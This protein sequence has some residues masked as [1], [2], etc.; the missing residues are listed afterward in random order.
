L[1]PYFEPH[2]RET[3]VQRGMHELDSI[4]YPNN[5]PLTVRAD[6]RPETGKPASTVELLQTQLLE[7]FGLQTAILN[8]LYGVQ[9]PFS[10]DMGAAYARALNDW[11]RA[12]WLDKDDRFRASI[13]IPTQSPELAV[14]EIERCAPDKRFVQVL[15]LVMG[16]TTLGRRHHWPIYKAAERHGLPIGIHAGSNYRHPVTPIGWP[17]TSAEDY[18]NQSIAFQSQLASLIAE[19]VFKAHPGLKFVF[20]ESGISWLPSF[21]WRFKK[22]WRGLTMEIPWVDRPP[23]EIVRDQV[24]FS[25]QPFDGATGH[26]DTEKLFEHLGSDD[27]ILFSTDYPHWQFDGLNA[28][29]DGVPQS[30]LQKIL[31][32]NPRQTY[33]RL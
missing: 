5:S 26:A 18:I 10:E 29:P 31:I 3:L 9:L 28:I 12:E 23:N 8:C 21:L 17:T 7:P 33:T 6:W 24:R 20:L 1:L 4:A 19:G 13:V 32:D 25:L 15:M 16:D 22:Y 27:F 30:M 11:I 2:W 14:E